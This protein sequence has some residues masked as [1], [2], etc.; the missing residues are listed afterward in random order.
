[1]LG[2]MVIPASA[3]SIREK[4]LAPAVLAV[5]PRSLVDGWSGQIDKKCHTVCSRRGFP[6]LAFLPD[7][8]L[9]AKSSRSSSK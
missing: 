5:Q 3:V 2:W 6:H 9:C 8:P 1:M 4:A 7:V